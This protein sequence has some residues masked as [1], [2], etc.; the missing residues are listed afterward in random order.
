MSAWV[1]PHRRGGKSTFSAQAG[2]GGGR[3]LAQLETAAKEKA[4]VDVA[5]AEGK[6]AALRK[7]AADGTMA[8]PMSDALAEA[9]AQVEAAK[10]R[11]WENLP[12]FAGPATEPAGAADDTQEAGEAS[13][14]LGMDPADPSIPII[15][16]SS[17][18]FPVLSAG[19]ASCRAVPVAPDRSFGRFPEKTLVCNLAA[20]RAIDTVCRQGGFTQAWAKKMAVGA[21]GEDL[22]TMTKIPVIILVK[23]MLGLPVEHDAAVQ[24]LTGAYAICMDPA[25]RTCMNVVVGRRPDGA[26]GFVLDKFS[27]Y[28]PNN[29]SIPTEWG[30]TWDLL[31]G[32]SFRTA[33]LS[34]SLNRAGLRG[35]SQDF[36]CQQHGLVIDDDS[37][38]EDCA[39]VKSVPG[40]S[41]EAR[42]A[43]ISGMVNAMVSTFGGTGGCLAASYDPAK[44]QQELTA[45]EDEWNLL[46]K[47]VGKAHP[48]ATQSSS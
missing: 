44:Q 14:S 11:R 31:Q 13:T 30:N 45:L 3:S 5:Q 40:E 39:Y 7:E 16:L 37:A 33:A 38:F 9:T 27:L 47:V 24:S 19:E 32:Y 6:L 48:G 20:R 41:D 36:P 28:Y 18:C 2:G 25:I 15:R 1:P 42:V 4:E 17:R 21:D 23:L 35:I 34:G 46:L 10:A 22:F 43:R 8:A 26:G 29:A 12:R